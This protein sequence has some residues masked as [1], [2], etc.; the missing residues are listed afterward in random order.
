M[1]DRFGSW[2]EYRAAPRHIVEEQIQAWIAKLNAE[3]EA[4]KDNPPK[5]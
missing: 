3:A 2:S 1:M 4:N 5:P